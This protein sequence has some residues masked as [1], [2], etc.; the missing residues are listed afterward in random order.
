MT[1]PTDSIG[2]ENIKYIKTF[3]RI[4]F[5]KETIKI[6]VKSSGR[7]MTLYVK[8]LKEINFFLLIMTMSSENTYGEI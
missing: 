5:R 6:N 2:V 1:L 8:S 4:N 7:L 3:D